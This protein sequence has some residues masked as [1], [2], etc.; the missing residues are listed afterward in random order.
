MFSWSDELSE[1]YSYGCS[2]RSW[3]PRPVFPETQ[4][5]SSPQWETLMQGASVV[6]GPDM[7][8][9]DI[10]PLRLRRSEPRGL[11]AATVVPFSCKVSCS[12]THGVAT[13]V[14]VASAWN[15]CVIPYIIQTRRQAGLP[16]REE[17]TTR[18]IRLRRCFCHG[19]QALHHST[20]P[21]C[22]LSGSYQSLRAIAE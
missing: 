8:A 15:R 2:S 19:G 14:F 13:A 17:P 7:A 20:T 11:Q 10:V 4:Q 3:S 18:V 16:G 5:P 22:I 21:R 1:G 9:P 12:L 6:M